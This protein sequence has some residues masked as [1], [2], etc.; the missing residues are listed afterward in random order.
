MEITPEFLEKTILDYQARG[1][2]FVSL[3]EV[4]E[5]VSKQKRLRQ[6]F[7]CFT[8]DDGY[9]DNYELAYPIFKKYNCPFAIYVTTDFPDGKA[10]LWWYVLEDILMNSDELILGDGSRSDCSTIDKKNETFVLVKQKIFDS[11]SPQIEQT[12]NQLFTNYNYSFKDK[13]KSLALSW[14]QIRILSTDNLCTIASHTLSHGVLTNMSDDR[15]KTELNESKL[16]LERQIGKK[17]FHFAY[18]YGAW[19]DSV[20]IQVADAGYSTAVLAN[21]G[22]VRRDNSQ[23]KLQRI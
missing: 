10:L 17:V 9:A 1:Y 23:F 2:L 22:K 18:P 12:L 5:I 3:D 8:F 4:H 14:E 11:Q 7:V 20:L 6:K 21:G 13:N 19:N 15:V 16:K